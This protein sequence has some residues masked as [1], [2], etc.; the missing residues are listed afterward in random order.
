MWNETQPVVRGVSGA[1][2]RRQ[3]ELASE[4]SHATRESFRTPDF[5]HMRCFVTI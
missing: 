2:D 5:A 1:F 4:A 3:A